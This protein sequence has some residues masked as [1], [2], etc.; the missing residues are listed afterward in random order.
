MADIKTDPGVCFPWDE[1]KKEYTQIKGDAE[2]VKKWWEQY[3]VLAYVHLW[4]C[5]TGL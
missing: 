3:D 4:F 1:K 2:M 5:V